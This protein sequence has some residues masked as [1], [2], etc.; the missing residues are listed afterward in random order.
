M[1]QHDCLFIYL[2]YLISVDGFHIP[3]I[4]SFPHFLYGDPDVVNS[5][6]GIRPNQ[7]EHDT[8]IDVEP[9]SVVFCLL[10]I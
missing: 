7:K 1:M 5:V 4:F 9:V 10:N 6:Y 2:F 8:V 3:V